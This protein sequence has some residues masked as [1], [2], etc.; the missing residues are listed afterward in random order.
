MKKRIV[1]ISLVAVTLILILIFGCNQEAFTRE[2][3]IEVAGAFGPADTQGWSLIND[4]LHGPVNI[5]RLE[6]KKGRIVVY[7]TF[8]ASRIHTF[9]VTPDEA[10]SKAGISVGA[11]VKKDRAEIYLT[12]L[13]DGR[14]VRID[15][16]EVKGRNAVFWFY[17]MFSKEAQK[18]EG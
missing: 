10:F 2:E 15:P 1:S 14:A 8:T 7:F 17:G 6:I 3:K 13:V 16:S 18:S 4:D 9:M 12:M 5:S 11:S